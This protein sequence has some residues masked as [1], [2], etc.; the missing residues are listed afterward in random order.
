[1]FKKL[2]IT[3]LIAL[4]TKSVFAKQTSFALALGDINP[5]DLSDI[6][7]EMNIKLTKQSLFNFSGETLKF[8]A[9]LPKDEFSAAKKLAKKYPAYQFVVAVHM[10]FNRKSTPTQFIKTMD[11]LCPKIREACGLA[12]FGREKIKDLE[13]K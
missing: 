6:E 12:E 11:T 7:L 8:I 5:L 1:M 9:F 4:S 2:L 10:L 13:N 3:S